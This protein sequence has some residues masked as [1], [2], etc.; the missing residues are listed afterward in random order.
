VK[1]RRRGARGGKEGR[2]GRG[3]VG[4]GGEGRGVN[5]EKERKGGKG[6]YE[7]GRIR[8]ECRGRR[9]EK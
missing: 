4:C 7:G 1:V 3:A 6:M 2:A 8:E 9:R 5:N